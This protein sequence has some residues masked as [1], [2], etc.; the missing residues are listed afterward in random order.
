[1]PSCDRDEMQVRDD[2]DHSRGD[3]QGRRKK[4]F[5]KTD[6]ATKFLDADSVSQPDTSARRMSRHVHFGELAAARQ[7]SACV[8]RDPPF[9]PK[10]KGMVP[11][12]LERNGPCG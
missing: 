11:Q 3:E 12:V 10:E 9:V 1:L 6:A 5:N 7:F 8:P 4:L 2:E